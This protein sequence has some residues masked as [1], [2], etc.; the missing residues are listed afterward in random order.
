M[1]KT[2]QKITSK[3]IKKNIGFCLFEKWHG[4]KNL[5]SS[6]I[7]GHWLIKYWDEAEVFKQGK[8]YDAIIFQ[9]TYWPDY[10][11]EYDSISIL[12]LC[13]PDWLDASLDIKRNVDVVDYITTSTEGLAEEVRKLTDTPV[14]FIPDRQDLEF[15]NIQ[16]EHKGRAKRVIWFGYAHNSHVLD[17]TIGALQ[18]R[19]LDLIVLSDFRPPY[20]K[21]ENRT[22]NIRYDWDN[23]EFDFNRE[24]LRADMVIM[25]PYE[26]LR[27]KFKSDN[28]KYTA[29]ALGMP[30]ATNVQELD[31]FMDPKERQKEADKRLKEV[32][33]KYDV[34]QSVKEFKEV[35]NEVKNKK[36]L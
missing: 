11:E 9:K 19:D 21:Y 26:S 25:P 4:K 2:S 18:K 33:E 20:G 5:G 14:K 1:Q 29:W 27:A 6:R 13:D 22:I 8:K 32:R 23:P 30:V 24:I 35:I 17:R 36:N 28:K 34:R 7:R 3:K 10:I 16:K 31:K 15:H 12:D